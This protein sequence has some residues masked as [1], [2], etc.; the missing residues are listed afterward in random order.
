MWTYNPAYKLGIRFDLEATNSFPDTWSAEPPS[1][2]TSGI[3]APTRSYYT[4]YSQ[5][6]ILYR[7]FDV[8]KGRRQGWVG[9]ASDNIRGAVTKTFS[10]AGLSLQPIGSG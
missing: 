10:T 7:H 5:S 8:G 3:R 6:S 4:S 9:P 2:W 1:L